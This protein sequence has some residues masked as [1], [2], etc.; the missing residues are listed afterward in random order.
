LQCPAGQGCGQGVVI[1]SRRQVGR[2]C[3][4]HGGKIHDRAAAETIAAAGKSVVM[5]M[6]MERRLS[7]MVCMLLGAGLVVTVA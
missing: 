2:R 5:T 3:A 6:L 4:E 7:V 1:D